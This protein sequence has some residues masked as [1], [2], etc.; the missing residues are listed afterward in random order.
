MQ[1]DEEIMKKDQ[2]VGNDQMKTREISNDVNQCQT[3]VRKSPVGLSL[4]QRLPV[5]WAVAQHGAG[6]W[7][8]LVFGPFCLCCIALYHLVFSFP[9]PPYPLSSS[10]T[11]SWPLL[12]LGHPCLPFLLFHHPVMPFPY[13]S[14]FSSALLSFLDPFCPLLTLSYPCLSCIILLSFIILV[15]PLSPFLILYLPCLS[16]LVLGHPFLFFII[17]SYLFLSLIIF[18]YPF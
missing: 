14:F 6:G 12:I 17:F 4:G 15:Y 2:I 18:A 13:H 11:L 9:F 10:F 3:W 8:V 5:G 1:N 16:F 7:L